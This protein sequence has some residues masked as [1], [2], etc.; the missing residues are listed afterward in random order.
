MRPSAAHFPLYHIS[1]TGSVVRVYIFYGD[2]LPFL[3]DDPIEKI[4]EEI[5]A[6]D[7]NSPSPSSG[8]KIP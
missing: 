2:E 1:V 8:S 7:F 3:D 4:V 5:I 6:F